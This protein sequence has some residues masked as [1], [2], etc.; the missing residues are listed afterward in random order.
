[1]VSRWDSSGDLQVTDI[2]Y[3]PPREATPVMCLIVSSHTQQ[4]FQTKLADQLIRQEGLGFR[5]IEVQFGGC[6]H[7]GLYTALVILR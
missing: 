4:E 3:K 6:G 2:S 1:M 7:G 5:N